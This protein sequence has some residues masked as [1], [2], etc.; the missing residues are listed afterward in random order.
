MNYDELV[1][2]ILHEQYFGGSPYERA[3]RIKR[4]VGLTE[5]Q[6]EFSELDQRRK[7]VIVLA[8]DEV[9]SYWEAALEEGE[10]LSKKE[11]AEFALEK[12]AGQ[13]TRME[14]DEYLIPSI[15][16]YLS[17]IGQYTQHDELNPHGK[18]PMSAERFRVLYEEALK[19]LRRLTGGLKRK[20]EADIVTS[21][22]GRAQAQ[23]NL[24]AWKASRR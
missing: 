19:K 17:I 12:F 3:S 4:H 22:E 2:Q 6:S 8:A 1:N 21:P 14:G 5:N 24:D 10:P 9:I 20:E 11:L 23:Q 16:S 7:D 18:P 15:K 13:E